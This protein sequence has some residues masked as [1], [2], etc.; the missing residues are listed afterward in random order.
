[1][2]FITFH[3]RT[4]SPA[5]LRSRSAAHSKSFQA[6]VASFVSIV[7]VIP[8]YSVYEGPIRIQHQCEP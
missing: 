2:E 5:V 4:V 8:C 6:R 3:A 1:M 7:M